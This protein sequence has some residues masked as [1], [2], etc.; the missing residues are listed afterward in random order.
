MRDK[1][2]APADNLTDVRRNAVR[3]SQSAGLVAEDAIR[4]RAYEKWEAAG[5]P[6]GDG[7]QFWL[8]A[9]RELSR[10]RPR[11]RT[12]WTHVR[13]WIV[14]RRLRFFRRENQQPS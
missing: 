7:V 10:Q 11:T 14:P 3:S 5:K 12:W 1:A 6:A 13:P 2:L 4:L 8:A 9:E